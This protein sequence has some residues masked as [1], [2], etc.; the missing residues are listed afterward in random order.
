MPS[1]EHA[2]TATSFVAPGQHLPKGAG[3][4]YVSIPWFIP[5]NASLVANNTSDA[6][7]EFQRFIQQQHYLKQLQQCP[8]F[9]YDTSQYAQS[10]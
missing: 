10:L 4:Q 3:D 1:L 2:G 7:V 8:A 9:D 5:R 6:A